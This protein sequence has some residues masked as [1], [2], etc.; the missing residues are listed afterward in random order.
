MKIKTVVANNFKGLNFKYTLADVTLIAGENYAG[1]SAIPLAIRLALTGYLPPPIGTKGVYSLAGNPTK[2][3]SMGIGLEL[4]NGRSVA[5]TWTRDAKGKLSVDGGV[6]PDLAMPPIL[7]EPR[8]F[9]AQTGAERINTIFESCPGAGSDLA[10]KIKARLAEV[11]IM[12]AKVRQEVLA[13]VVTAIDTVFGQGNPQ[14]A[15]SQLLDAL[16]TNAKSAADAAKFAGGQVSGFQLPAV[17]PRDVRVE[18]EQARAELAGL[19]LATNGVKAQKQNE[20]DTV[21]NKLSAYSRRYQGTPVEHLSEFVESEAQKAAIDL[22]N[23]KP[24]PP[25]DD[26]QEALEDAQHRLKELEQQVKDACKSWDVINQAIG[27][28]EIADCCPTCK[29]SIPGWKDVALTSLGIDR[30]QAR[31]ALDKAVDS[32]TS[33]DK[34][35]ADL[36]AVIETQRRLW[37]ARETDRTRIEADIAQLTTDR[38]NIA[39]LLAKK[40][41]LSTEL[42]GL[43][44]DDA[45]IPARVSQLQAKIAELDQLHSAYL[46]YD[47]DLAKRV[48]IENQLLASQS[49]ADVLK[50]VIKLVTDEQ[51]QATEAAFSTVLGT[52]RAFTDGI[53]N[54]PL[55]FVAGDLGRRVSAADREK[56]CVAPVGSWI[57]HEVFSDSE[58][59]IAYVA[60][61][62]ALASRAPIRLVCVDELATLSDS[63][64]LVF[65]SR[66]MKLVRDGVI[67]QAICCEPSAAAYTGTVQNGEFKIIQL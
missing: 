62:V 36:T 34:Q 32:K 43:A 21:V 11:Q 41:A 9:F 64:K 2:P 25:V 27:N 4:D 33:T 31:I 35:I 67:D 6:P 16:K 28:L 63:R 52:A 18:L 65:M 14:Q 13:E 50:A 49:K 56:G 37:V 48:E 17:K 30:Q 53:L 24:V 7:M 54:S 47:R 3:G 61:S 20:L 59:R 22:R 8:L 60:F 5:W 10:A 51:R 39:Q 45:T 46:G 26:D 66:L 57:S 19:Q 1:K 12:P 40:A 42:A 38:A 55:E 15:C 58:Q 44:A 29:A 23:L